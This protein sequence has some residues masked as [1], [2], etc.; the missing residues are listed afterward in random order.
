MLN[1]IL[2]ILS[3]FFIWHIPCT[4]STSISTA[5]H[6]A[7]PSD[8]EGSWKLAF[9]QPP[10]APPECPTSI[11]HLSTT[12]IREGPFRLPHT[13]ILHDFL[14]CSDPSEPPRQR[15]FRFYTRLAV[16]RRITVPRSTFRIPKLLLRLLN[17][18]SP[19]RKIRAAAERLDEDYFIGFEAV[20]RVCNGT[21][22]FSRGTVA[23][24]VRPLRRALQVRSIG[25]RLTEGMRWLVMIPFRKKPC[26]YSPSTGEVTTVNM[27]GETQT[28]AEQEE[29]EE[30]GAVGGNGLEGNQG[31][32]RECF[33]GDVMVLTEGGEL[34]E[35]RAL[36]V[37]DRVAVG[38]GIY[39]EVF[40]FTHQ[41][42]DVRAEFIWLDVESGERVGLT[43]GHYLY[44]NGGLRVA[45]T[46]RNGDL[47]QLSNGTES[48]VVSIRRTVGRGLYN[49]QTL[50]GDIIVNG[51]RASTYTR[52]VDPR[53][54]HVVLLPIR[55]L[56][57][58]C[59]TDW[60]FGMFK[61]GLPWD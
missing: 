32:R 16:R 37:G 42:S 45:A 22:V 18:T 9:P 33:P 54:A 52:A 25:I 29:G 58:A 47:V 35:M 49:P 30:G 36:K 13:S 40:M 1:S 7:V 34:R 51:I 31:N 44:V 4:H 27:T 24:V 26:V 61:R 28:A 60:S 55:G 56:Y 8:I 10:G 38:H 11:T 41:D 53:L 5:L 21:V 57:K 23:Y 14:S 59:S 3:L 20:D 39:S 12:R 46:V 15:L 19:V 2:L 6:P 50:H 17:T 43:G 48:R